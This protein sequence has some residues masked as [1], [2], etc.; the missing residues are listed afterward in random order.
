MSLS[1]II[2]NLKEGL[3]R[4]PDTHASHH[5]DH[6]DDSHAL[7]TISGEHKVITP[8]M[9]AEAAFGGYYDRP[10]KKESD[11]LQR[12]DSAARRFSEAHDAN[13]AAIAKNPE[14]QA[15]FPDLAKAA[16]DQRKLMSADAQVRRRL[17]EADPSL[18]GSSR[19][20]MVFGG[21]FD[22]HKKTDAP[23]HH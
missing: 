2:Q 1:T 8:A 19:A 18:S 17:S 14:I 7:S 16:T 11:P 5:D 15:S 9:R 23:A 4:K 10:V 20:E 6:H 12:H 22:S 21:F 13:L 3:Q